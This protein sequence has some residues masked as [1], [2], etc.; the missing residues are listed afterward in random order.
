MMT[1]ER[2][3]FFL[4]FGMGSDGWG[5]GD[6]MTGQV[7]QVIEGYQG[8][9]FDRPA[10][11]GKWAEGRGRMGIFY[12]LCYGYGCLQGVLCWRWGRG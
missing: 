2:R 1:Q 4:I 5:L 9:G 10:R 3:A 8:M 12:E 6:I 11:L 7:Y